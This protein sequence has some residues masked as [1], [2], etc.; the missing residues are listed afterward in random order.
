MKVSELSEALDLVSLT[1]HNWHVQARG[2]W[3]SCL[4]RS[5]GQHAS[6]ASNLAAGLS[7]TGRCVLQA[8]CAITGEG[9]LDGLN[10]I[11]EEL[12]R[13]QAVPT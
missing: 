3:P 1:T 13:K 5:D 12:R 9:L 4:A 2:R 6:P 8:S 11:A 7:R 10:W